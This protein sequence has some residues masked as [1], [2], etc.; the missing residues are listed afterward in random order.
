MVKERS[1]FA[2]YLNKIFKISN[3]IERL[4]YFGFIFFLLTHI[5]ACMWFFVA[6][7]DDF[8]PETWFPFN[9]INN[10][11]VV[12]QTLLDKGNFDVS[13]MIK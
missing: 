6:K 12:R 9:F 3:G 8:N 4:I 13:L 7:L 5:C 10:F 11:R 1:K 2:K